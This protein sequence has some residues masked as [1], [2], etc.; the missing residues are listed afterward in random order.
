M[1]I[2]GY[3]AIKGTQIEDIFPFISSMQSDERIDDPLNYLEELYGDQPIPYINKTVSYIR[4]KLTV[5][6]QILTLNSRSAKK[7]LAENQRELNKYM[8]ATKGYIGQDD[9]SKP[10]KMFSAFKLRFDSVLSKVKK[11]DDKI[12][13]HF[14]ALKIIGE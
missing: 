4:S 1:F 7:I 8:Q 2:L 14:D 13:T 6:D 10:D 11:M 9:I 5:D 12:T 3:L